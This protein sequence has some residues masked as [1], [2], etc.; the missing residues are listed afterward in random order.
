MDYNKISNIVVENIC[1]WDAP[2]FC[3]ASI[4]HA[5]YE[6]R[7]LTDDE[8]DKLNEDID[9]VYDAVEAYLF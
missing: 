1:P 8:L 2:D 9:F 7:E 4:S 3:D 5:E 6:G